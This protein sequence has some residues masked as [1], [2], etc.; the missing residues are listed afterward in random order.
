M[1]DNIAEQFMRE[2]WYDGNSGNIKIK[3]HWKPIIIPPIYTPNCVIMS[4]PNQKKPSTK[5]YDTEWGRLTI[6]FA[7][8]RQ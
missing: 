8:Q 4:N 5:I 3:A 1:K 2:L 7:P 6:E